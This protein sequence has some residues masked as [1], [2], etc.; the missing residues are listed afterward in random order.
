MFGGDS[1]NPLIS[2]S[3]LILQI[4]LYSTI[5]IALDSYLRNRWRKKGGKVGNLPPHLPVNQDV[6]D[7][8]D[9]VK[10]QEDH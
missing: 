2:L 9:E 3:A 8:E 5:N 7:H 1:I 6:I 10:A 4:L